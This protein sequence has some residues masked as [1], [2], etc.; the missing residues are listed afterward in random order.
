AA[1]AVVD[2]CELD[3]APAET[4]I[5]TRAPPCAFSPGFGFCATTVPAG[6]SE[7]T[8]CVVTSNPADFRREAASDSL[9]PTTSGTGFAGCPFETSSVTA[10]PFASRVP[11]AGLCAATI[12]RG[13]VEK[14]LRTT[15]CSPSSRSRL[16]AVGAGIPS[17][18]ASATRASAG[19]FAAVVVVALG[20]VT[21]ETVT[22]VG[23]DATTVV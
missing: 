22:V 6:C 9:W 5:R 12:P 17:T 11:A 13:F 16:T 2:G 10:A 4:L 3:G 7:G 19:V 8:R 23:D 14:T 1:G 20:V 21:R 18:F 15:G